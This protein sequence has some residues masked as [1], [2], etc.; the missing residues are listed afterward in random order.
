M[1]KLLSTED[2]GIGMGG[3]G[4]DRLRE[5]AMTLSTTRMTWPVQI[6]TKTKEKKMAATTTAAMD[7]RIN[8]TALVKGM[9]ECTLLVKEGEAPALSVDTGTNRVTA[10]LTAADMNRMSLVLSDGTLS[11]EEDRK[12]TRLNSSHANISYAV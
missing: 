3:Y 8:L 12:S 6:E 10:R 5:M 7:R 4:Q 9:R 11:G 2:G 1:K